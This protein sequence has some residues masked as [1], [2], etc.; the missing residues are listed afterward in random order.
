MFVI[1]ATY[2]KPRYYDDPGKKTMNYITKRV[3]S[4]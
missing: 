1:E 4:L 2:C 3:I